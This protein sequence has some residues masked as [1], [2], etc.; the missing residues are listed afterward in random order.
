VDEAPQLGTVKTV[1]LACA[2]GNDRAAR[3]SEKSGWRRAVIVAYDADTGGTSPGLRNV[4]L[5]A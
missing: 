4:S 3:F 2:I 5:E 1:W